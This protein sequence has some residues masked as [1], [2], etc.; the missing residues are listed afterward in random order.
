M[1][2]NTDAEPAVRKV[3][4]T[5]GTTFT[6][7][8]P[9]DWARDQGLEA[10][11]RVYVYSFEDRV[12]VAP[13]E[14]P[15]EA[16]RLS[17]DASGV[18]PATV[19]RHVRT[20]YAAGADA[21]AIGAADGL[22]AA[23]RRA[24]NDAVAGLVGLRV[25]EEDADGIEA[26]S[27]LDPSA[28]SLEQTVAQL[29][30][31]VLTMLRE[32]LDALV[33]ADSALAATAR[34]RHGDVER[35]VALV[36]RQFQGALVDVSEVEQLD[37]DRST[38]YRQV[39]VARH[40]ERIAA[41]ADRVACVATEQSAAPAAPVAEALDECGD[42]SQQ[43]IRA[44]LGEDRDA[45]RQA[46]VDARTRLDALEDVLEA[47]DDPDSHRYGRVL[48]AFANLTAATADLAALRLPGG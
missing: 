20:A 32:A 28:V 16:R 24:A 14:R 34:D 48:E 23:Q 2:S 46:I 31:Q 5:G 13:T 21:I 36:S 39:R 11:S 17:V 7:S 19:A 26:S 40:L 35:L 41:A 42:A 15:G 38:A 22:T 43:A 30:Q 47:T 9:K 12:V 18:D 4:R 37:G 10:G 33:E 29:R 6:V 1:P 44:A 27:M 8:L 3:Q 45:A 25:A